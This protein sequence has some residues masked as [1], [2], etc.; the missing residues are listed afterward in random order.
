MHISAHNLTVCKGAQYRYK[1]G[2]IRALFNVLGLYLFVL[3]RAA[4]A[5]RL[6]II[7]TD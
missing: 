6:G 2:V 5:Y 4:A 7:N 3:V 1:G